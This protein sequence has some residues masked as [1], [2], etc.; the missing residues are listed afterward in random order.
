MIDTCKLAAALVFAA[1]AGLTA[2][3]AGLLGDVRISVILVRTACIF[4]ATGVLVYIGAFLFER[5]GYGS[6]IKETEAAMKDLEQ[7]EKQG[8][9]QEQPAAEQETAEAAEDESKEEAP[10]DDAGEA[11]GF[12]PMDTDSLRKVTGSK[13]T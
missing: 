1:I 9:E 13:D 4:L 6:I 7:K 3:V 2:M 5:I 10:Q 8:K 11:G 12:A